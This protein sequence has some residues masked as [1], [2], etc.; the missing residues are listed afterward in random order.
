MVISELFSTVKSA[1]ESEGWA[2]SEV[3]EREVIRAGFEAQH[4]RV[5]L[6]LQVFDKLSAISVVSESTFQTTDPIRRER[7]AELAM[8][9][10]QSLTLGNF[11]LDWDAGRL[12]FRCSNLFGAAQGDSNIVKGLIHNTIGEMDRMAPFEA[13]IQKAAVSELAGIN[14]PELLQREDLLP[15]IPLPESSSTD[16]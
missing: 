8:R 10:N 11:E 2:Y 14:I 9:V 3:P 7:L 13:L 16:G 5:D 6:H 12:M 1:F 4:T 15:E